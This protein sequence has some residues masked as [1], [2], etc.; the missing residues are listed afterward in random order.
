MNSEFILDVKVL[1]KMEI[2]SLSENTE[3]KRFAKLVSLPKA[4]SEGVTSLPEK[5]SM[6]NTMWKH[7]SVYLSV[8]SVTCVVLVLVA[9]IY[10]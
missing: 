3:R 2:I 9:I 10:I 4:S 7:V 5:T 6:L 8:N 1:E